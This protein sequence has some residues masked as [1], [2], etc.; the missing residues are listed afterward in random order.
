MNRNGARGSSCNTPVSVANCSVL[1]SGV[2]TNAELGSGTSS[3][4]Y[5]KSENTEYSGNF[6]IAKFAGTP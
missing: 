5:R 2:I 3:E 6:S 4:N 1:P